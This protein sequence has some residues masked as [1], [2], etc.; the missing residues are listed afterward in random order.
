MSEF[1]SQK[2]QQMLQEVEN[3][4][5]S[6]TSNMDLDD[7]VTK[8]ERGYLLIQE[9]RNRLDLTKEKVETIREKY[10]K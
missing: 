8:I 7:M 1:E 3:I 4:V 6:I 9:M 5:E 10:E 2:Y